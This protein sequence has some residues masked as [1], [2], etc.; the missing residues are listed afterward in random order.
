MAGDW[1]KVEMGTPDKPEVWAVAETLGID[2]D[3]AFGKLFRIW[4]WFDEQTESGN[5]PSVTK[6]LLDRK[7]GVTGFCDAVIDA[8]WMI[9]E[10]KTIFLPN[11]DRHTGKTAKNRALTAKRAADHRR[12]S[13]DDRNAQRNGASV[14]SALPR[15]EK[16]REESNTPCSPPKRKRVTQ[17]TQLPKDFEPN[18]TCLDLAAEKGVDLSVE[19]PQFKDHYTAKGERRK[20]WQ[21]SLRTWIRNAAKWQKPRAGNSTEDIWAGTK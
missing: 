15:E 2:P 3:A 14:T 11:F 10:E 16:R 5:A 1:L 17:S 4:A 20:D 9:E 12:K 13:N 7:V 6:A 21:A 8:G 19:L 18:Q